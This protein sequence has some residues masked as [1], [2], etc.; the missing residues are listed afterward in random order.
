MDT[1]VGSVE[2]ITFFNRENG[3][4]V[5]RL[6]PNRKGMRG[7]NREGLATVTGNMPEIVVG[8]FLSLQGKWVTHPKHGLQFQAD[9]CEQTLPATTTGIHRY[10]G[11]GLIKG[12]GPRLAERIVDHFGKQTLDVIEEQPEKL[13]E[14]PD[15]GRKRAYM[16]ASAWK[17]QKHVKDIMI[18][19]HSYGVSTNLAIKVYKQYGDDA[20]EVVQS[21]PYRLARDIYGVG[22]KTADKIAQALG[23]PANH[24]SRIQAGVVYSLH[25]DIDEGH[26]YSPRAELTQ[27]AADLL[28]A[29]PD[30]IPDALNH[31]ANDNFVR[32][33]VLPFLDKT[34]EPLDLGTI[35][36]SILG[37]NSKGHTAIY[38]TS[39]H[40]S[41]KGVAQRFR[42]LASTLPTRLS[43]VPPA[44]IHLDPD[45][46]SEQ[47]MAIRTAIGNPLSILTGGPGTG[48][49]TA[50]KALIFALE[51]TNKTYALASPTGRAAKRLSQATGRSASTIHRLLGFSPSEG[52]KLNTE[53]PLKVDFLVIDEASMMDLPLTNNLLKAIQPGTHLLLVGDV[54]QLPSVGPGD[55]LRDV[56]ASEIA[57]VTRL[58]VIFR[59][60]AHS[61]II[62]NAHR[63]NQGLIP[64]FSSPSEARQDQWPG[65]FFL[66]PANTPEETSKWIQE[67]VCSRIPS[68]FGLHPRDDVQVLSPMYRG[69]AGVTALNEA[70]QENLNP[71]ELM[72]AEKT[73]FGQVFRSGDK[74]M[75]TRNNYD[76]NV[77]NG[78][79]G[80]LLKINPTEQTL[81]IGFESRPVEYDWNE[82]DQLT[83]A[84]AVSVHKSQGSEFPAVVLPIITQ[85][86]IML[87]RNLLYTA[88]T[89]AKQLC[90]LVGNRRAI[91]IAAHNDKVSHRHTALEWRLNMS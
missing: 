21:D 13:R 33:E 86:Y 4:C 24:P 84:Y 14:V 5:L 90:V 54:D 79:I 81:T 31:L 26:V 64:L 55:V 71:P 89:R 27:Q 16:I 63:I 49:T 74:L 65:D 59:Q 40:N 37:G 77:Y 83:L 11:S 25:Q 70:L 22:F 73:L 80:Y 66:F 20:L 35:N 87:Q 48:K 51:S 78:D 19:L 43:D 12:I 44:F 45:L 85:H 8:E 36:E 72:K 57:P 75:Q 61:H 42:F 47:Q 29:S 39:L 34:S 76:K 1:L 18:F 28:D 56:I 52:F 23:L 2:R 53:N 68:K 32:V 88:I 3:Y 6:R 91:A 7:L 46:S 60:A 67:I 10:L 62:T 30:L 9:I 38:L 17:E 82:A 41:E 58:T 69:F 15:I 50:L